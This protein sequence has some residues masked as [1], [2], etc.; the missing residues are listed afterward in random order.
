MEEEPNKQSP[1]KDHPPDEP[2][3]RERRDS[4]RQYLMGELSEDVQEQI[5]RRLLSEDDYFEE[6]LIAEEEL[7]DDF[8]GERL[9]DAESAKFSRR[10]LSVPELRQEV[11]FAKALR[12]RA[13][14]HARHATPR[15][16]QE[17]PPPLFVKLIAFLRRPAVGFSMAAALLLAVCAALWLAAQNRGL[18]EQVEE[19]RARATATPAPTPPQPSLLEQLASE[20]ER[21]EELAARLKSEQEQ[22]AEAERKLEEARVRQPKSQPDQ[23]RGSALAAVF[24]LSPGLV[25]G[26]GEGM[27][28]ISVPP[29]GGRVLLLLDLASDDYST[30]RATLKTLGGPELHSASNLRARGASGRRT[31]A[32]NVPAAKLA[33]AQDYEIS[34]GGKSASG[35]YDGVGT[36]N[37]R[38]VR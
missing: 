38:V 32:F 10:F 6:I 5:E 20:R 31:V 21:S 37:F 36:Y 7:A 13:A 23:A 3:G 27:K 4:I 33:P 25:R 12:R 22:R 14:E 2:S 19:L 28:K 18:R 1:P 17:R 8:V 9:D 26:A 15:Q 16:Q 30:Y 11:R 34:L 24:T 29:G 35:E